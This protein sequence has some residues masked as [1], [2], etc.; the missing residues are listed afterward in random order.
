MIWRLCILITV[1][2]SLA[3][4]ARAAGPGPVA[5]CPSQQGLLVCPAPD[6]IAPLPARTQAEPPCPCKAMLAEADPVPARTGALI[7]LLRSQEPARLQGV[8]PGGL[9]RP[10]RPSAA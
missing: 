2:L 4:P 7:R 8:I 10:P 6:T 3:L 1:T 5:S 9:D